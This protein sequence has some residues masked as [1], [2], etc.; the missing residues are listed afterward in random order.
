MFAKQSLGLKLLVA[1]SILAISIIVTV[2]LV[3]F[4]EGKF[5]MEDAWFISVV[6]IYIGIFITAVYSLCIEELESRQGWM[7]GNWTLTIYDN[8]GEKIKEDLYIVKHRKNNIYADITRTFPQDSRELGRKWIFEG[9]LIRDA[10]LIGHYWSQKEGSLSCGAQF[11]LNVEK[12]EDGLP[13]KGD[14]FK[15]T[16]IKANLLSIGEKD[17]V[18][19]GSGQIP[20][21][22]ITWIRPAT[23]LKEYRAIPKQTL[24]NSDDN[25][26]NF[27]IRQRISALFS[28]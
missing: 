17:K 13:I 27:S 11:L 12:N 8:T 4:I 16:Y 2:G 15:G 23:N 5:S 25:S 26:L 6:S 14:L 7:T 20:M 18:L 9:R 1:I 19:M 21:T 24:P 10:K 22:T 3:I 28:K